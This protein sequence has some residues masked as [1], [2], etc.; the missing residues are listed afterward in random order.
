MLFSILITLSCTQHNKATVDPNE[1]VQQPLAEAPPKPP[2][3]D[4]STIKKTSSILLDT[5]KMET[6]EEQYKQGS[7]INITYLRQYPNGCFEQQ[8]IQHTIEDQQIIHNLT[9][10]DHTSS[11]AFCS[12]AIVPGG[13]TYELPTLDVG[14]YSGRVLMNDEIQVEYQLE[15]IE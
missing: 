11:G 13:F 5:G 12:L 15:I 7:S 3:P 10:V 2:L 4:I 9:V 8:D 1:A 6:I 14:H